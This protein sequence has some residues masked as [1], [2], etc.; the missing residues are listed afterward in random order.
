[1]GYLADAPI[2]TGFSRG[3]EARKITSYLAYDLAQ[4][5]YSSNGPWILFQAIGEI[6]T[7]EASIYVVPATGGQWTLISKSQ[8]WD[9]KPRWSCDGKKIYFISARG[10]L[11]NVWGIG[12]DPTA[13]QPVGEAFRVTEFKN[14]SLMDR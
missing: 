7:V 2:V 10:G 11:L 13:G 5:H 4:P 12:F 3:P 14:P 1:V 8:P 6:P 9:D